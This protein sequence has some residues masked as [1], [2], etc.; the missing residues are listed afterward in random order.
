MAKYVNTPV[1]RLIHRATLPWDGPREL[2]QETIKPACRVDTQHSHVSKLFTEQWQS[3]QEQVA[4]A[5]RKKKEKIPSHDIH[6]WC[7]PSKST[8]DTVSAGHRAPATKLLLL[9]HFPSFL[10]PKE[11][12]KNTRKVDLPLRK[13]PDH[14][15]DTSCPLLRLGLAH[16]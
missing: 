2:C 10:F 13:K 8:L 12:L 7:N 14:T 15:Q 5:E 4:F 9:K 1:S 16:L 11:A 3:S 6:R